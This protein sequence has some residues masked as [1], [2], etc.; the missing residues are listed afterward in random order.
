MDFNEFKDR[1]FDALNES[2]ELNCSGL[3]V[4]DRENAFTLVMEDGSAFVLTCR[5]AEA[6]E[7]N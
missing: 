6:G 3:W 4:R 1:L 5:Q 2:G 7:R